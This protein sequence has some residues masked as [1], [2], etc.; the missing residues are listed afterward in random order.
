MR[1]IWQDENWPALKWDEQALLPLLTKV[2]YEQGRLLGKM[3]GLGFEALKDEA[4]LQAMTD[5]VVK[6]S[7]IE[8]E[9]LPPNEVRSS[10]ARHLGMKH[11]KDLVPSSRAVDGI[12]EL[13]TDATTNYHRPLTRRRLFKWHASLFPTGRS[14]LTK[15]TTGQYR[16]GP[17]QVVSGAIGAENIHYEAPPADRLNADMADFLDWLEDP[18]TMNPLLAAGLAHFWFVTLHPFDDGN[19]RIARAIAD[20]ALARAENSARRY[21]SMS[22]QIRIERNDYYKM[23]E[24]TQKGSCDITAWQEWFLSCLRR[25]IEDANGTV[26]TVLQKAR[27][28]Q[29]FA[30]Q[31]LNERQT[32]VLNRLLDG[33]EG[34]LTTKKWAAMTR[35]SHD[36]ALRDIKDLIE[37]GVLEQAPGSGRSTSYVVVLVR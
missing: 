14:G 19:G 29:R 22:K 33:F 5:E 12:V 24:S 6:S 27:F 18:G 37:R 26:D 20:M 17:V 1:Y 10:I 3:E 31:P 25:A 23:L 16:D 36:T 35:S 34:K 15:I 32:K 13:M 28:W 4:H 8:G 9:F 2:S 11:V 21:Y 7:E 30:D